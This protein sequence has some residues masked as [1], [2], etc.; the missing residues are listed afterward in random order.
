MRSDWDSGALLAGPRGRRLC[1]ELLT[2]TGGWGWEEPLESAG[3]ARLA[4]AVGVAVARSDVG[5]LAVAREPA[6]FFLALADAVAWAM[7][8]Q[9]PDDRDRRLSDPRV[10]EQ[11]TPV[12]DAVSNALAARWWWWPLDPA[13]QHEVVFD[14]PDGRSLPDPPDDGRV[15]LLDWRARTLK[16]ESSAADR[17]NDPRAP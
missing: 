10:A 4:E 14:D 15:A 13:I 16:D 11:L 5:A 2:H 17:P 3:A 12:A 8:W 6:S 9:E 7:Y 1:W